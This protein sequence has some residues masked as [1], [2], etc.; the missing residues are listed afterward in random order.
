MKNEGLGKTIIDDLIMITLALV[1]VSLL[2]FEVIAD[3]TVEQSRII[4]YA[5]LGIALV[6]LGDFTYNFAKADSKI[7]FFKGHW[8][9]LLASI[10]I[11]TEV[12]QSLRGLRLI[13]VF[14]LIRLLRIIRLVVRLRIILNASERIA[15]QT[16]LIY[17]FTVVG[18]VIFTGALSFH[19]FEAD[20]NPNVSNFFDSFYWSVVTT[21]TVGYGDISPITIGGRIVA[22][23][24]ML[25]G[26]GT[27]G[28]VTATVASY[29]IKNKKDS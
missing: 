25:V 24:L 9:E 7:K 14:R 6:F 28:A 16:Y 27:L 29:L 23:F 1:S 26:I 18:S 4:G 20:V 13:R 12:T 15:K 5:D 17:I 22:M 21:A 19:F 11:T 8:W 3:L 10:P 2:V